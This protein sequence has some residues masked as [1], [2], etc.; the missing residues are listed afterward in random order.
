MPLRH[1][2]AAID[3]V[4]IDHTNGHDCIL[5]RLYLQKQV[6]RFGISLRTPGSEPNCQHLNMY[7]QCVLRQVCKFNYFIYEMCVIIVT[8]L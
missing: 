6:A 3:N 8:I 1:S 4:Y 7:E 5:I 2:K